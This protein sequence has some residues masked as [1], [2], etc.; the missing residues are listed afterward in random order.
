MKKIIALVY[1]IVGIYFF[2]F[3]ETPVIVIDPLHGGKDTGVYYVNNKTK[4]TVYEKDIVLALAKKIEAELKECY[5]QIQTIMTRSDD[6]Y[7]TF[8]DREEKIQAATHNRS[9]ICLRLHINS[10]TD[11]SATGFRLLIPVSASTLGM[12]FTQYL[13][14]SLD[15]TVG[16][17]MQNRGIG[18]L[19][20]TNQ[21]NSNKVQVFIGIGFLSN[22]KDMNLL[23]DN[24][25]LVQCTEGI[26]TGVKNY[27]DSLS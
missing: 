19:Q 14:K 27:I 9:T 2:C 26:V 6:S 22:Q 12:S 16:S 23:L 3:A 18:L 10:S 5:P 20:A 7:M 15:Q 1:S 11:T 8:N 25:F 21:S 24:T 17:Y 4:K 13:T